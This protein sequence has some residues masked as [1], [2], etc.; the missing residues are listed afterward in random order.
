MDWAFRWLKFYQRLCRN[1]FYR[2]QFPSESCAKK[3]CDRPPKR[4]RCPPDG[5]I[6]SGRRSFGSR[7]QPTSLFCDEARD[8]AGEAISAVA[9]AAE[10]TQVLVA[11]KFC[12]SAHIA[13]CPL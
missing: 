1:R 6:S 3:L 5:F 8:L 2:A 4:R 7:G 9:V 11:G 13:V 10:G 12:D